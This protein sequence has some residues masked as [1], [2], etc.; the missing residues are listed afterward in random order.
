MCGSVHHH[1]VSGRWTRVW[2]HRKLA[3]WC[4]DLLGPSMTMV[5]LVHYSLYSAL[6]LARA[7]VKNS[8]LQYIGDTFGMHAM[9]L[10]HQQEDSPQ[11][12]STQEHVFS[13][14]S[15][16]LRD[17]IASFNIL[18]LAPA[19]RGNSQGVKEPPHIMN[20]FI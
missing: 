13:S 7:L 17:T 3:W 20:Y 6:L 14:L 18:Y 15:F 12:R 10:P 9:P 11:A 8:V 2:S 19:K 1:D 16:C 5:Q 4:R